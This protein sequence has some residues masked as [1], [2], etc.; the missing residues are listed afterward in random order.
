MYSEV[1]TGREGC[2]FFDREEQ[3]V[4]KDTK[5]VKISLAMHTNQV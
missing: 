3:V 2:G 4:L 5:K 1:V